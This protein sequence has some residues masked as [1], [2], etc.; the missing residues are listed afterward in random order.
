MRKAHYDGYGSI[1]LPVA[2]WSLVLSTV[3][4]VP[5]AARADCVTNGLTVTC[6][7]SSPNPYTTIIGTGPYAATGVTVDVGPGATLSTGDSSA[8]SLADGATVNV[9]TGALV[10]NNAFQNFGLYGDG[11]NTVDIYNDSTVT[12]Q[13][14]GEILATGIQQEA[15][16]INPEGAGNLIVNYGTIQAD[17]AADIWFQN[18]TGTNT[19][20]N[21]AGA[22]ME[23]PSTTYSVIGATA[24]GNV[25]FTNKG[26]IIGS[27]DFGNG[28][29]VLN[30]YTGQS[31]TGTVDGGTGT[32]ALTLD[33]T[34]SS[35]LDAGTITDFQSLTKEDSGI[36]T[37]TGSIGDIGGGSPLAVEVQGGTLALSGDNTGFSGTMLV[38][39][40]GILQA[41][42]QSMT[43]AVTDNGQV[44]FTQTS[45]GTYTGD[46]SGTGA[47]VKLDSGTLTL[48][49][50]A[51][52]GNS[53]SGGTV[54][55]AGIVAV[56]ADD[57]L[58]APTGSLTFNGG[59]LQFTNS[60]DLSA[61]RAVT[62]DAGGGTVDTDGNDTALSQGITGLGVLTKIGAGRL[63]LNGAG[64]YTGGTDVDA[65]EL[66]LG[67]G[68]ALGTGP[69]T[70]ADGT[71]LGFTAGG[72]NVANPVVLSGPVG[73]TIDTGSNAETLS[74]AITGA[75]G[76]TKQGSGTLIA[77][78]AGSYSGATELA[79][80]TLQAGAAN[81]FSPNSAYT[82]DPGATMNLAGYDQKIGA[83][84]NAGTVSLAGSMPGTV[85]T[86][87]GDYIGDNG[88]LRISTA[89]GADTSLTDELV[90]DG[91]VSGAT[92][93]QVTNAGG[94]GALTTGNGIEVVQVGG[95]STASAFQLMGTHVDAGAYQYYLYQGGAGD[96]NDF[97]LRSDTA[98]PPDPVAYRTAVPVYSA[99]AGEVQQAGLTMLGNFHQR[100]GETP[101][102]GDSQTWGRVIG[103]NINIHQDG[104]AD[105]RSNGTLAGFQIGSDLW[106]G[107][108]WRVGGYFGYLRGNMD[109][110]GFAGGVVGQ[111]GTNQSNSY[112]LGAYG[113]HIWQDGSYLDLVLQQ[114][115]ENT[116]LCPYGDG[117]NTVGSSSTIV[118]AEAGKHFALGSS[119]WAIEP[120]AQA[121]YQWVNL[122]NA[123]ISGDTRVHQSRDNGWLFRVGPRLTDQ[124]NT[125]LGP[126]AFYVR[127]NFYYAP[128]GASLTTFSTPA[129][130]T[131][132]RESG[133]YASF[134]LAGGGTL[135]ISRRVN[136][137]TEIGHVWG[138]GGGAD[139]GSTVEGSIG[140][141]VNW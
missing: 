93:L 19:V 35:T 10:E 11:A 43:P 5:A 81:S 40:N 14:G 9:A 58:G 129:A 25:N 123:E 7:S 126:L 53:Y 12:V 47:V 64:S 121:I 48:D 30:L 95:T 104:Q 66:D 46:I 107:D 138:V 60:F 130:S 15:E 24:D 21:E 117:C 34:G 124:V 118:S 18:S 133:Q 90:V 112:F 17:Y 6:D 109:V 101:S 75:G 59:T 1:R 63:A 116:S 85:L 87:A 22:L 91:N 108:G 73:P 55:D 120:Q 42:S 80:G 51:T 69:L 99:L 100:M 37:V 110:S 134:E 54:F 92:T 23:G 3:L 28:N 2:V 97:F 27:L 79:A 96:S 4:V 31:I 16:P 39:P 65:G 131:T 41:S 32:N 70:M 76:F 94:L 8:I 140:L 49:P 33:G 57:A 106:R 78:G 68:A 67:N 83:L 115:F 122:D 137:Y 98:G 136:L 111:A 45:D 38:D 77:S 20:I 72:L 71:T 102:N 61:T 103:G 114:G 135:M 128:N 125:G 86:V 36:W 56:G 62:L 141:R 127:T 105:A 50:S 44:R 13:Q 113:T 89:L 29:N 139:V 119:G 84:N 52:G 132:L 26:A 82:V 74:G 88:L